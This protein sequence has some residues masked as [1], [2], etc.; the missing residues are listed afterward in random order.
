MRRNRTEVRFRLFGRH[1]L[2]RHHRHVSAVV[3]LGDEFH[4]AVGGGEEG[5]VT[6]H[7]HVLAGPELGPALTNDDVAGKY[8]LAAELLHAETTTRGVAPV[9]RRAARFL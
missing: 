2:C 8:G 6:A 9:A 4:G 7:A 3:P 1:H 5:M